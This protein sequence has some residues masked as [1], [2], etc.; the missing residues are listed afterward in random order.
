M[1]MTLNEM[2]K[3]IGDTEIF[4]TP[5]GEITISGPVAFYGQLLG[6][7]ER[8]LQEEKRKHVERCKREPR[9]KTDLSNAEKSILQF[10]NEIYQE[11][12]RDLA[13]AKIYDVD[14]KMIENYAREGGIT[15]K[16][17]AIV[18]TI[19]D[20]FDSDEEC[21]STR[22]RDLV[23][24][25]IMM[26]RS[27]YGMTVEQ[28][29]AKKGML[30][31]IH[32]VLDEAAMGIVLMVLALMA[33]KRNLTFGIDES[34]LV[35]EQKEKCLILLDNIENGI[36]Q[37]GDIDKV[38]HQVILQYP[39]IPDVYHHILD[40]Y[41]DESKEVERLANYVGVNIHNYKEELAQEFL[42]ELPI[43]DEDA[44]LEAK[45]KLVEHCSYLGLDVLSCK[46]M[47]EIE[48]E[49]EEYEIESRTVEGVVCETR[50]S[51]EFARQEL[52]DIL[53]FMEDVNPPTS[54]SLLDYEAELIEKKAEFEKR[55]QS[56]VKSKFIAEMDT[57]LANFD[58]LFCTV[59]LKTVD[60]KTAGKHRLLKLIEKMDVYTIED[61]QKAYGQMH[62]LL[63]KVG[64]E[65]AEA[66]ETL[67][68]LEECK[69]DLALEFVKEHQGTTEEDAISAKEKLIAYCDEIE[70]PV[71]PE[72]KAF[73]HID[74]RLKKFDLEYRTVDGVE[75]KTRDSADFA[76][77][78]FPK[79]RDFV[80]Q[81]VSPTPNSLLD[82][83]QD[84]LE[85]RKIF[86]ETFSS[87]LKGKYL[88]KF[89]KYLSDF[90][91]LF[92]SMG[93][94]KKG[95][96]REAGIYRAVKFAKGLK[97][98]DVSEAE[99]AYS[100]LRE[101]LPKLGISEQD[102]A[103]AMNIIKTKHENLQNRKGFLGGLFKL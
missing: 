93:L 65:E 76:K 25:R 58:K 100:D 16:S 101:M 24:E 98:S 37:E 96:R 7:Y 15:A 60:R 102:A 27:E 40:L 29:I 17:E 57:Y 54:K 72:L 85:R 38:L 49:L 79:I 23:S 41:G 1:Y 70:L 50:E 11:I 22:C 9:S 83:E 68:Y 21:V 82:Y 31:A 59:A 92:C 47:K 3:Q 66:E 103:E 63:P 6:K 99:K 32:N 86:D 36:V 19:F 30:T 51:A 12:K 45:E 43:D 42:D 61:I 28:Y 55:F 4:F 33:E 78:E 67:E 89:D 44:A 2:L 46:A 80:N 94:L 95:T 75:C 88:K 48:E 53:K 13:S 71:N 10:L 91:K 14:D 5:I 39:Y 8:L 26:F 77:E 18:A 56:E 35:G 81:L 73:Q 97:F 87:E 74:K 62:E 69:G 64:I 52:P 20:A 90:D 34:I 84:M